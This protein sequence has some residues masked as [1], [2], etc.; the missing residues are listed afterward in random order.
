MKS[1]TL[2]L[3]A[4][5]IV[6]C[7]KLETVS[8]TPQEV[9]PK[10]P[11]FPY[12]IDEA[13]ELEKKNALSI[14]HFYDT[15]KGSKGPAG[16]LIAK[17]EFSQYSF[18]GNFKPA[19]LGIKVV[20][21]LYWSKA[22]CSE[23]VPA[24]GVILIPYGNPPNGGWPVVVWAHGTSGV[25]RPC[26][27]SLM[28]DLYYGWQGLLQWPMLGYAVV[29]PD[30]A[31][32]GTD[33][34]HQYLLAPAQ[35]NDVLNAVPA[36][37]KAFPQLGAR[38]VAV[39]HSQGATA[40]LFVAELQGQRKVPDPNYLGAVALSPGTDRLL[41]LRAAIKNPANH[42]YL[43]FLAYGI[44]AVY[45]EFQY[46]DFLTPEAVKLMLV[47]KEG[48]WFV[49]LAT[50]AHKVPVGKMVLS[51]AEKNP[52]FLK[53]RDMS[54]IGLKRAHGPIFLAQGDK[55]TTIPID[56]VRIAYKRMLDQGTTAE[57]K[58]YAGLDHDSL[59]FG[60]FRDQVRWVQDRFDGKPLANKKGEK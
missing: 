6:S 20:R 40:V 59:V 9:A 1:K 29:A 34:P 44:K 12:T 41:L 23:L 55:D 56:T 52:H 49:T 15:P 22:A 48:G 21:F 35:A 5:V 43:A 13:R 16:E 3:L 10:P 58:E 17:E 27:P 53:L 37:R 39:G 36:A 32:L 11:L 57:Y 7:A 19:D 51:G 45:P 26:A 14:T 60:S 31:G 54:M 33:V 4:L 38:W 28:K 2:A 25:G 30:Y 42:G 18:P 47:V 8:T 50:F 24:S 46:S